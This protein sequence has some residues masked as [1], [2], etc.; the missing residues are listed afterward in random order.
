MSV[1]AAV[2]AHTVQSA[3]LVTP[4]RMVSARFRHLEMII[5]HDAL[6]LMILVLEDGSTHKEMLA[7]VETVDQ[8]RLDRMSN[9]FNKL[10]R[11]HSVREIRS[12]T[13]PELSALND[14]EAVVLE[15][16]LNLM[17]Q[18]DR[19]SFGEIY[20]DGLINV[21]HQPEFVDVDKF[22]HVVEIM[23]RQN[24]LE[25]ILADILGARGVQIIIGGGG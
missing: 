18:R 3:S 15:R 24:W 1:A 8:D 5:L 20:R 21:L 4:P 12:S 14:E 9:K 17:Q 23:E 2:L 10:L 13:N 19:R 25:S 22:R 16:V 11:G 6:Y 7:T